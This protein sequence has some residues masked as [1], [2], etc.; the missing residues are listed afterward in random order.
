MGINNLWSL[1]VDEAL[2]ADKL[3]TVLGKTQYEVFF[4]VNKQLKHMDLILLNLKKIKPIR[5][6]V[7][8]SRTYEPQGSGKQ[9]YGEGS[10]A[11]IVI[12]KKTI[13]ESVNKVD[14]YI[15]VLHSLVDGVHKKQIEINYLVLPTKDLLKIV[16]KKTTRKPGD[17]HFT[18]W[19]DGKGRRA[20]DVNNGKGTEIKMSKFLDN[21]KALQR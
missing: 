1:T 16:S 11:W 3:K 10:A 14:F 21:W 4:P 8:G 7:K 5:M 18:I 9:R 15:F 20:F 6:Q 12:P 13:Q 19:I 2:L 17:Y